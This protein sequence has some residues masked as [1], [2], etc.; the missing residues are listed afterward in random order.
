MTKR[1]HHEYE[2]KNG[3]P[4]DLICHK[5]QTIWTITDYINYKSTELMTIPKG[6][7]YVVIKRQ[8]EQ[9]NKDNPDH[10]TNKNPEFL[11]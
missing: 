2:T 4:D 9:F 1:C 6:V 5:C 8:A 10:Y 3:Y 11:G 7:R